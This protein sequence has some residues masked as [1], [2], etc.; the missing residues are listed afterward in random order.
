MRLRRFDLSAL[1]ACVAGAACS[2]R[3]QVLGGGSLRSLWQPSAAL[4]VFGGTA[5]AVFVSYPIARAAAHVSA[6]T[7]AMTGVS[8][9]PEPLLDRFFGYANLARRKGMLS[10]EDELDADTI[11]SFARA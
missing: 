10:L 5:V 9:R 3:A 11:R 7:Q 6:L 4:I 1:V 2:W 8:H